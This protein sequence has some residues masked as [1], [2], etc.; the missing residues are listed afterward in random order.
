M[1]AQDE[2]RA[3]VVGR[4]GHGA[5]PHEARD[6]LLAAAQAVAA[7]QSV[8]SR[9]VDPND[10][11]VVTVGSLRAGTA[12]NVIPGEARLEG[13]MRSFRPEVRETLRRRVR[14]VLEGTVRAAG[15]SLEWELLEGYPAVVNDPESA[16]AAREAARR[17]YGPDAVHEPAPLCAAEDF[18]YFLE[19]V[20]GAF[21]LVGAGSA[22]RGITAPHHSPEFDID[23]SVLPLGAEL[24]ARLATS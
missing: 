9:S 18:A 21:V 15:C 1:A 24:L 2:F 22:E 5:M 10:P 11:A 13:T 16:R 4:G 19:R 17:V 8:V 20:P 3:R 14:Q 12:P 23:E 6:P 7:L